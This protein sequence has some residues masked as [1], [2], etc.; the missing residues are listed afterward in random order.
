MERSGRL[1]AARG[2]PVAGTNRLRHG[3]KSGRNIEV[4]RTR[5]PGLTRYRCVPFLSR[6]VSRAKG[7]LL[8]IEVLECA[9]AVRHRRRPID[10]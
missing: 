5:C 2:F 9:G 8:A 3:Y 10:H 6:P 7:P 4:T 1:V